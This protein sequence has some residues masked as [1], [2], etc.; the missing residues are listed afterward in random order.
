[1]LVCLFHLGETLYAEKGYALAQQAAQLA[2]EVEQETAK[3]VLVAG[4]IPPAF[5]SYRP[6]LFDAQRA[7]E[8]TTHLVDAQQQY[9]DVWLAETVASLGEMR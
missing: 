9:V 4:A 7:Q 1:M 3:E 2:R 6:D 8:I 5:G